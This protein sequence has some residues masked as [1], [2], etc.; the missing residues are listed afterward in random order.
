MTNYLPT[1]SFWRRPE[2][3]L[4]LKRYLIHQWIPAFAGMTKHLLPR[5]WMFIVIRYV[6]AVVRVGVESRGW[7]IGIG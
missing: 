3:I 2:S 1:M 7:L 4:Y 6:A 5:H